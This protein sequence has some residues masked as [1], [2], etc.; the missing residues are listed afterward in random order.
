MGLVDR[1]HLFENNLHRLYSKDD[2]LVVP[3]KMLLLRVKK[4]QFVANFVK[5][6]HDVGGIAGCDQLKQTQ[7]VCLEKIL[8]HRDNVLRSVADRM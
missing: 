2:G 1:K 4:H 6:P 8:L 7:K 5:H 3:R